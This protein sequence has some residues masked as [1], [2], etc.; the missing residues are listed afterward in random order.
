MMGFVSQPG[1]A[2]TLG[3]NGNANPSPSSGGGNG[4]P[5]RTNWGGGNGGNINPQTVWLIAAIVV[6]YYLW[7]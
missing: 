1:Q 4:T 5:G 3:G 2:A 6:L 7:E